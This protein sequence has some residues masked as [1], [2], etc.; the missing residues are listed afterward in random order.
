MFDLDAGR[1]VDQEFLFGLAFVAAKHDLALRRSGAVGWSGTAIGR[2]GAT[3]IGRRSG[4]G[5]RRRRSGIGT[6]R[7]RSATG[8]GRRSGSGI[9]R[10]T[11]VRWWRRCGGRAHARGLQSL[12]GGGVKIA[13]GG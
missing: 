8:I 12:N 10:R 11:G 3:A 4:V 13:V 6:R 9:R 7:R 2:R 5:A 1:S